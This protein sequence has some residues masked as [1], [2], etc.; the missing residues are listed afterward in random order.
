M[1]SQGP[2]GDLALAEDYGQGRSQ[3]PVGGVGFT[4]TT[5]VSRTQSRRGTHDRRTTSD[6]IEWIAYY[7]KEMTSL[8]DLQQQGCKR[9]AEIVKAHPSHPRLLQEVMKCLPHQVVMEQMTLRITKDPDRAC[10]PLL[11]YGL[12][13]SVDLERLQ[14]LRQFA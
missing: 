10:C 14:S 6:E 2:L 1:A 12:P 5:V 13:L 11:R 7:A 8:V 4:S 9:V 3:G